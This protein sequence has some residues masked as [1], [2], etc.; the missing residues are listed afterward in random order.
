MKTNA[1]DLAMTISF[2][3]SQPEKRKLS[4]QSIST[5]KEET[6]SGSKAKMNVKPKLQAG[7]KQEAGELNK[8]T[9][10]DLKPGQLIM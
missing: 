8:S 7:N 2:N 5:E 9:L 3:S 6:N 10:R 4:F 1:N